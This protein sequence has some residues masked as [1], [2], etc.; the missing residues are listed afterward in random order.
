MPNNE[1]NITNSENIAN[2]PHNDSWRSTISHIQ[3]MIESYNNSQNIR[4]ANPTNSDED[5]QVNNPADDDDDN[6]YDDYDN[7]QELE[8]I[9]DLAAR[10]DNDI[11]NIFNSFETVEFKDAVYVRGFGFF[12]KDDPRV[13]KDAIYEGLNIIIDEKLSFDHYGV[14][15]PIYED[16]DA[17]GNLINCKY[18]VANIREYSSFVEV[19]NPN[20]KISEI[21]YIQESL[22]E[23]NIFQFYYVENVNNGMFY[24][25]DGKYHAE[26]FNKET[27]TCYRKHKNSSSFRDFCKNKPKTYV[28]M[29]DKKYTWGVE[30]E[31]SSGFL[32]SRLDK[33][34]F[35][36]AVHDGSLRDENG[37]VYGGE[38]VTDVLFGDLGLQNLKKLCNELSKRCMINKKCGVHVH[39]GDVTFNKESIILMYYLYSKLET[40]IFDM[41]PPSRRKN[42]YCRSLPKLFIDIT[43]LNNVS[44]R[45][46]LIDV[47][48]DQIMR[49]LSSG[50]STNL[51]VNKKNDHPKGF[52][53]GYDHSTARY[54]WV[55]FIPAVFNT[56]K[57]NIYTI[58][59]RPHSATTSYNKI[60]NW[61]FIC[62]ALI[63][64]V[65]N[66][67]KDIYA[68]PNIKLQDII[69]IVYPKNHIE[70]N[71]YIEKRT[72]KFSD[73]SIDQ[74][75]MDYVENE[76][77]NDLTLKSL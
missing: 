38:Y 45:D 20:N 3:H 34:L 12:K 19:Y 48:Y 47:Y 8:P 35:Y 27:H 77:T 18:T 24:R 6:Y 60:K 74:E 72:N 13:F 59:F 52:K 21:A 36:S 49:I 9:D 39:I 15:N 61:L 10:S 42:E 37:S 17:K 58:E 46:Y 54:C 16:I 25:K 56:R 62:I 50:H 29:L 51:K 4:L 30:I 11:V 65:E 14:I 26:F 64:I 43:Q 41:L 44:S 32:P 5:L 23:N 75:Q 57:N 68:N 63:D 73:K 7:Q 2:S 1:I 66:H 70:I 40:Q 69:R 28:K 22:I 53:C 76:I 31:T 33:E 55:N 67:K 71:E